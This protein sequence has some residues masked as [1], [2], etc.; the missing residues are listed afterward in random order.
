MARH[1]A[2]NVHRQN[3][4]KKEER[5]LCI[6]VVVVVFVVG[7]FGRQ[8]RGERLCQRGESGRGE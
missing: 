6:V 8:R 5:R 4:K 3:R 2:R 7:W 1:P